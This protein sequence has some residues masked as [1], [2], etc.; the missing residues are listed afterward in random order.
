MGKLKL[1]WLQKHPLY[2]MSSKQRLVASL[3]QIKGD[4]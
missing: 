3:I 2:Q 1:Q 4:D